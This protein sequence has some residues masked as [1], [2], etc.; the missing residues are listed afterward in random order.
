M[1]RYLIIGGC[2]FIGSYL[3]EDLIYKGHSVRILDNLSTGQLIDVH[4]FCEILIGDVTNLEMVKKCFEG[5]DYCFHLATSIKKQT[6]NNEWIDSFTKNHLAS[7][8]VFLSA[9]K[10]QVP[11]VYASS[12][13]S[14]KSEIDSSMM[15]KS[16]LSMMK[17]K[18]DLELSA[19][20][21]ALIHNVPTCGLRLFNIYGPRENPY[22]PSSS[23]V[24]TLCHQIY[25]GRS[26]EVFGDGQQM[27]DFVYIDDAIRFFTSAMRNITK[28]PSSFDVCSGHSIS[29]NELVNTIMAI[30]EKQVV[31]EYS[32]N[33]NIDVKEPLGKSKYALKHLKTEGL[34]YLV[35]GLTKTIRHYSRH[36]NQSLMQPRMLVL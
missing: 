28:L 36:G 18:V 21:A 13:I 8:N 19:K 2:G 23:L 11:V 10:N 26:V 16:T 29:V 30:C 31:I 34:I 24:S 22:K 20:V 27:L 15:H 4:E 33:R 25:K 12:P 5:I 35:D 7:H 1:S 3:A 9:R 14:D 6:V 32:T 17:S